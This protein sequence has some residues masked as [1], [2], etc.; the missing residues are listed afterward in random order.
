[1]FNSG[2]AAF[3]VI[4]STNLGI[5]AVTHLNKYYPFSPFAPGAKVTMPASP[6]YSFKKKEANIYPPHYCLDYPSN[7][8][9]LFLV[10]G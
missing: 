6:P 5:L 4:V 8:V 2:L 1:M 3:Y 9:L 10:L 7:V